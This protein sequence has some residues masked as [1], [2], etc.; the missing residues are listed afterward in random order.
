MSKPFTQF[1]AAFKSHLD[2]TVETK[3]GD[4]DDSYRDEIEEDSIEDSTEYLE[5]VVYDS[6]ADIP[7]DL[8]FTIHNGASKIVIVFEQ[9]D[10]VIKLPFTGSWNWI[11]SKY[12]FSFRD[13]MKENPDKTTEDYLQE[14]EEWD[15]S[16][17]GCYEFNYFSGGGHKD[18]HGHYVHDWDYCDTEVDCYN[19]A[20]TGWMRRIIIAL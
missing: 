9:F 11:K 15:D 5:R 6:I 18:S 14:K 13:F 10:W 19:K 2:L 17:P 3:W 20:K 7:F 4:P 8:N 16:N 12:P 1:L